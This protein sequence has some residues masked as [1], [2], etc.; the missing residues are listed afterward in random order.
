MWGCHNILVL[1]W[2]YSQYFEL[3]PVGPVE[4]EFPG[5]L[6]DWKG[7]KGILGGYQWY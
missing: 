4:Q 7:W 1:G 5:V 3:V 6:L 2:C